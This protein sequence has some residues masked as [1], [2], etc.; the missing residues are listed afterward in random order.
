MKKSTAIGAAAALSLAACVAVM[1]TPVLA[2]TGSATTGAQPSATTASP[3]AQSTSPTSNG[4]AGR[5]GQTS[6]SGLQPSTQQTKEPRYTG[7]A[8]RSQQNTTAAERKTND[9][10]K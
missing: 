1:T 2:Q 3:S 5:A 4:A 10:H 7:T 6:D 9:L 8:R